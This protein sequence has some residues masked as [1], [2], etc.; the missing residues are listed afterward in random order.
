[1][2]DLAAAHDVV[3]TRVEQVLDPLRVAGV[4]DAA[5]VGA[6]ARGLAGD[7]LDLGLEGGDEGVLDVAVDV[8]VVD[9]DAGLAGVEPLGVGDAARAQLLVGVC[10]DDDGALAAELEGDR[11][12]V[13]GRGLRDDAPDRAVAGVEDVV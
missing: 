5:E 2:V 8:D 11:G 13:L 9:G 4:D 10:V 7:G 6:L 12:Q 1:D 3:A